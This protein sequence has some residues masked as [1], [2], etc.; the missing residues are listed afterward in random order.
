MLELANDKELEA[1][2]YPLWLSHHTARQTT[3]GE[4]VSYS[5][6]LERLKEK[7]ETTD[8]PQRTVDEIQAEFSPMIEKYRKEAATSG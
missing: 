7:T 6:L 2:L 3:G 5:E 8:K 1:V 4:I